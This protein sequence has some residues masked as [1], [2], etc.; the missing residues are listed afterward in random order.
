MG[1]N[2]PLLLV[3]VVQ[4][5]STLGDSLGQRCSRA[6][7]HQNRRRFLISMAVVS[8]LQMFVAIGFIQVAL[9]S[10][11][12]QLHQKVN[13]TSIDVCALPH[14]DTRRPA[15][16]CYAQGPLTI[17]KVLA[18]C[19]LSLLN[20]ALNVVYYFG[21]ASLYREPL[22]VLLLVMA[23][24]L[25]TFV[26]NPLQAMLGMHR[27]AAAGAGATI[28]G[29]AGAFL[30]TIERT[31]PAS[32]RGSICQEDAEAT[33]PAELDGAAPVTEYSHVNEGDGD[34]DGSSAAPVTTK[35]RVLVWLRRNI[36]VLFPFL[37]LAFAYALYFV[38]MAYYDAHCNVNAWGYNALDQVMLPVY[39]YTALAVTSVLPCRAASLDDGAGDENFLIAVRETFKSEAR[40]YGAGFAHMF[41]YRFLINGR[42]VAYYFIA[43]RYDL[44]KAYFVLTLVRVV[45]S[46]LVS[47]VLVLAVPRF[48]RAEEAERRQLK[49][50]LNLV[51][52]CLGTVAVI[53]SLLLIDDVL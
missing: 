46:W 4:L 14:N 8:C 24:L 40:N 12:S 22:G 1:G 42:A 38:F 28:L 50:P 25:S 19:P 21:E 20:G 35:E 41:A 5:V 45:L 9:P 37:T 6:Y 3:F 30:C 47:L 44:A 7:H 32:Q 43:S 23:A 18:S 36:K 17:Y 34:G 26:V 29:I 51:A 52:K 13:G 53:F 39:L 48:I 10:T 49:D 2:V 27:E 33:G 16:A 11:A 31:A 15:E